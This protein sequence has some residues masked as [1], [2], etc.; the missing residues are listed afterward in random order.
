MIEI[1]E[2]VELDLEDLGC[3]YEQFWGEKFNQTPIIIIFA[4]I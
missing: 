2:L 1:A 3:L 4:V